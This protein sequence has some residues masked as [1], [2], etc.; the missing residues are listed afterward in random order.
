MKV[1]NEDIATEHEV[2]SVSNET[3][4]TVIQL[5]KLKKIVKRAIDILGSIIGIILFLPLTLVVYICNIIEKDKGPI[6]YTQK[7]IGKDGK[8]FKMYK[9]RSM[10]VD[11][12]RK[13]N[14]YLKE[15]PEAKKEYSEYKKLKED[16]RITKV[17]KFLRKSSLD[18]FPQFINVLKGEMSL[19]GPRPYLRREKKEMG[20][21]YEYIISLKPGLT[22]FW[23]I[24]GRSD[25]TF[26]D[27]LEMDMKYYKENSLTLDMQL[28][29]KTIVKIIKR[30]GAL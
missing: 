25:V 23:Q 6:F 16:P 1:T 24:N 3:V 13:L 8:I 15:H 26:K 17:G 5:S 14:K 30:E 18:E 4:E 11:A 7:R 10:V 19:V 22:G 9:Y 28:L 21:Y 2:M 27:R 12:D 20:M 29:I